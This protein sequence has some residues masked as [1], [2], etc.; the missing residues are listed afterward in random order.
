MWKRCDHIVFYV[1]QSHAFGTSIPHFTFRISHNSAF[2]R[3]LESVKF[4]SANGYGHG[5][6]LSHDQDVALADK[7]RAGED[8]ISVQPTVAQFCTCWAWGGFLTS[9]GRHLQCTVP[10]EWLLMLCRHD[11]S[12]GT[13]SCHRRMHAVIHHAFPLL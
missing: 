8:Y 11:D 6:Q 5:L 2:T 12:T 1:S 7:G 9:N 13:A 10:A 3:T 4:R